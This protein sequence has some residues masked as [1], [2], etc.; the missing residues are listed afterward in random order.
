[1]EITHKS[2]LE[3]VEKLNKINSKAADL[4]SEWVE[5]YGL[6]DRYALIEYAHALTSKYGEAAATLACE[7][8]DATAL[9]A[10]MVLPPAMPAETATIAEVGKAVNGSLRTSL[11]NVPSV[12]YR[13]SKQAAADTTLQNAA[14]DGAEFAWVPFGE[15]C[16]FCLTLASRGWQKRSAASMRGSH[17]EHIHANCDCQYSTR[18]NGKGGVQGYDPD[19]YL[20]MYEDANAY[21]AGEVSKYRDADGRL[22]KKRQSFSTAKINAM[23]REQYAENK[24]EIN[25]QKREAYAKRKEIEKIDDSS[26][27]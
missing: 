18:F 20:R 6:D 3:Y 16:A 11:L 23:R 2:W 8:Y 25:A 10:G 1:M 19:K 26:T 4:M 7:M 22:V 13:L 12:V 17:A 14:R 15:T 5:T 21:S 24:D 9:A 27:D